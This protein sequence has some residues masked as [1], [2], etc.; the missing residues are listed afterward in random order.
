[1]GLHYRQ[2]PERV[3]G[4]GL[5][6][7]LWGSEA[8]CACQAVRGGPVLSGRAQAFWEP[9]LRTVPSSLA[10]CRPS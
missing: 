3:F 8:A 9:P 6:R 1:M 4:E 7:G 5:W 10:Q 2:I